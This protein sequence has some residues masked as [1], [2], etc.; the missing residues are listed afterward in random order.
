MALRMTRATASLLLL[1]LAAACD[2]GPS[3]TELARLDRERANA[4]DPAITAALEDPIMTD[5]DLTV[6]DNSRRVRYVPG[7]AVASAPAR[8]TANAAVYNAIAALEPRGPAC[9]RGFRTGAEWAA[10]LPAPFVLP[11]GASLIEASGN[12]TRGCAAVVAVYRVPVRA[13]RL[14]A[15][16]RARAL[17]AGYASTAQ[18]RGADRV[19]RGRRARDGASYY[20]VA[21]PRADGSEI[22]LRSA[23]NR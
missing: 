4:T 8:I 12:T 1:L 6:A 16:L 19:L 18:V 10:R 15:S 13:D 3:A 5:R 21:T 23:A 2:R 7:P 11:P 17:A 22:A 9:E 14:V 20:L